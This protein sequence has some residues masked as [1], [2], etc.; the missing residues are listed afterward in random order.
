VFNSLIS[1]KWREDL[2]NI[3]VLK[4]KG[5]IQAKL[6][7]DLKVMDKKV[8]KCDVSHFYHGLLKILAYNVFG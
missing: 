5:C 3:Y 6:H 2:K 4:N 1:R 7:A 8:G